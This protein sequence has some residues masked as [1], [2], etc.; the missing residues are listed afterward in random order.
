MS[1]VH[2]CDEKRSRNS[3]NCGRHIRTHHA[4]SSAL[5]VTTRLGPHLPNQVAIISGWDVFPDTVHD[6]VLPGT[7]AQV[8]AHA[9]ETFE[10]AMSGLLACRFSEREARRTLQPL[11]SELGAESAFLSPRLLGAMPADFRV[12]ILIGQECNPRYGSLLRTILKRAKALAVSD[13]VNGERPIVDM[14]Q[15]R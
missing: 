2:G 11:L 13:S 4:G 12:S 9:R 5:F 1:D 15:S 14:R 7:V 10:Q 8:L 3:W 6:R